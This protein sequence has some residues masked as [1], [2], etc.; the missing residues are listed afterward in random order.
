MS[1]CPDPLLGEHLTSITVQGLTPHLVTGVP[2][3]TWDVTG[4]AHT[5]TAYIR[6]TEHS[7]D[8]GARDI[9]PVNSKLL[10]FVPLTEGEGLVIACLARS[11]DENVMNTLWRATT[12]KRFQVSWVEGDE[13]MVGQFTGGRRQGGI[14]DY[15][16]NLIEWTLL[17][18]NNG[19]GPNVTESKTGS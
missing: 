8:T 5:L 7:E 2:D 14:S 13:T 15:G 16:E 17:P 19:T 12:S 10:N 11:G 1:A 18:M 9:R 4:T 3:G 6:R